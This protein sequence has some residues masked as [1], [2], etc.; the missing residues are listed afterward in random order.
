[1]WVLVA[2]AASAPRVRVQGN[3]PAAH[4]YAQCCETGVGIDK[5]LSEAARYFNMAAEAGYG[6]SLYRYGVWL[7]GSLRAQ[8]RQNNNNSERPLGV[9]LLVCLGAVWR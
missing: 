7:T 3:I 9:Q 4:C 8:S 6:P 5:N 1:M 2:G